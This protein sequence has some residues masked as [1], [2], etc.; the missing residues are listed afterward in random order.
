MLRTPDPKAFLIRQQFLFLRGFTS[1]GRHLLLPINIHPFKFQAIE[2]LCPETATLGNTTSIFMKLKITLKWKAIASSVAWGCHNIGKKSKEKKRAVCHHPEINCLLRPTSMVTTVTWVLK[3]ISRPYLFHCVTKK[4]KH[5][6]TSLANRM[7]NLFARVYYF[8]FLNFDQE[9]CSERWGKSVAYQ[10]DMSA[11]FH[12][13]FAHTVR[14]RPVKPC[15]LKGQ[16]EK[17]SQHRLKSFFLLLHLPTQL[18]I[19]WNLEVPKQVVVTWQDKQARGNWS[20]CLLPIFIAVNTQ[21]L[22][23]TVWNISIIWS[24]K[25][26]LLLKL[27]GKCSKHYKNIT[28]LDNIHILRLQAANVLCKNQ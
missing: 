26:I 15:V 16:Q 1:K 11:N 3:S 10:Q 23:N 25:C 28:D 9:L 20:W 2:I 24:F 5:K 17:V 14:T 27:M 12:S 6:M 18:E 13:P 7:L 8:N 4:K 21:G 22:T 19:K